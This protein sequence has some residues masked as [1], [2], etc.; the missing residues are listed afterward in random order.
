MALQGIGVEDVQS[1]NPFPWM[2]RELEAD[3]DPV[4]AGGSGL[5]SPLDMGSSAVAVDEEQHKPAI[6]GRKASDRLLIGF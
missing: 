6:E 4:G 5:R 3:D 1:P 2:P